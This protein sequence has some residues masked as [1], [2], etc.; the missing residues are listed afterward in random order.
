MHKARYVGRG[1]EH[2]SSPSS[3]FFRHLNVFTNLE[4]LWNPF[5]WVL[6]GFHYIGMIDSL[7]TGNWF[8]LEHFFP[9][10]SLKVRG[11]GLKFKF[12]NH[13]IGSPGNQT[14]AWGASKIQLINKLWCNWKEFIINNKTSLSLSPLKKFQGFEELCTGNRM[15][16][17]YIML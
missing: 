11:V 5:F 15:K 3:P 2:P 4:A 6:W 17:K 8:R 12:S 16:T 9:L 7:A 10:P 13:K 1:M 14:R